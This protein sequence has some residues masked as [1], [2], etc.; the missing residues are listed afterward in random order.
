MG[1]EYTFETKTDWFI[2]NFKSAGTKNDYITRAQRGE[3]GSRWR[4]TV[5]FVKKALEA[6]GASHII[7]YMDAIYIPKVYANTD[8]TEAAN[9][10]TEEKK[11]D[12]DVVCVGK[13]E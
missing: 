2:K 7:S 5:K 10:R 8:P 3:P 11:N 4:R 12:T 6:L 13:E 9:V 1:K